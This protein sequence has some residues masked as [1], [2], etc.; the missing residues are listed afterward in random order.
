MSAW[1]GYAAA[2]CTTLAFVPQV[3]AVVRT[4][5]T[6]GISLSMYLIFC[7]GVAL[8]LVYGIMLASPPLIAAN[9]ITLL[10]AAVVLAYKMRNVLRGQ[11]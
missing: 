3:A 9:G 5:N 6:A 8:W 11:A 10:L 1:L 7:V 2:C 4:H